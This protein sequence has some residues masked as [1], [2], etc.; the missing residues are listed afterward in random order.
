VPFCLSDAHSTSS[1]EH[2]SPPR[3]CMLFAKSRCDFFVAPARF[4][5]SLC[6]R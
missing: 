2:R 6:S 5:S 4:L 1:A 3:L